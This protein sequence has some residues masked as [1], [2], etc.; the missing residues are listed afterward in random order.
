[1]THPVISPEEADRSRP[2]ARCHQRGVGAGEVDSSRAP[3][4]AAPLVGAA[5]R[6]RQ[7]A[8]S[9]S[10]SSSTTPKTCGDARTPGESRT[11][12]LKGHWTQGRKRLFKII[13]DLVQWENTTNETVLEKARAEIRKAGGRPAS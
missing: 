7:R 5:A 11:S 3:V 2:A 8:P 4:H 12:K 6:W 1:M 13:E 9:S 10:P